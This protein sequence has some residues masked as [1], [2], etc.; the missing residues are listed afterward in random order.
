ME[1][2]HGYLLIDVNTDVTLRCAAGGKPMPILTW[3]CINENG[4][5]ISDADNIAFNSV[6]IRNT[7]IC[8][9]IAINEYGTLKKNISVVVSGENMIVR[10]TFSQLQFTLSQSI[11]LLFL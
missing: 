10:L 4:Q 2:M 8:Q 9:C 3:R 1:N 7:G 6:S 5:L 11:I